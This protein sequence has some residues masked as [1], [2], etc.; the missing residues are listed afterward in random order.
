MT[1]FR[2]AAL[3][4]GLSCL[5]S[6]QEAP[7]LAV[8]VHILSPLQNLRD[9]NGGKTGVGLSL[10][11]N[12]PLDDGWAYR[13]H[14]GLDRFPEGKSASNPGATTLVDVSHLVVE[15]LFQLRDVPGPYVFAGLGAYSWNVQEDDPALVL[16]T[17]RR[18]AHVGGSLG[19]GYRITDHFDIELRGMGGSVDPGFRAGWAGIA[20]AW[21]F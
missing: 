1:F 20:A 17:D 2:T 16:S 7:G 6:A 8:Q 4:L 19:I 11:V 3:S 18:V 9:A 10:T 14:L 13:V 12:I 5:A 21:R 15:G